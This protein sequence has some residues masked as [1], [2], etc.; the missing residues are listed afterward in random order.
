MLI[1]LA[2]MAAMQTTSGWLID[3]ETSAL[4]GAVSYIAGKESRDPLRNA[5]GRPEKAMVAVSCTNRRRYAS[6]IW[7]AYLGRDG[8]TARW[9]F[10]QGEIV[11]DGV[12]SLGTTVVLEGRSADRFI[13]TLADAEVL[14][15]QVSGRS[16]QQEAVFELAGGYDVVAAVLARCPR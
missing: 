3:E 6:F 4:D 8:V 1:I 16:G 11:S 12:R 13:D 2:I 15:V 9:R 7:P 5:A 14:V 10:D